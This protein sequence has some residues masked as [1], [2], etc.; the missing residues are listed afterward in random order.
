MKQGRASLFM[1]LACGL[2]APMF[3]LIKWAATLAPMMQVIY[4]HYIA[5]LLVT[6]GLFLLTR[7][8]T[9]AIEGKK[10]FALRTVFWLTTTLCIFSASALLPVVHVSLLLN[11]APLFVPIFAMIWL[12]EKI[13]LM[14][15]FA[16]SVAFMGAALVLKPVGVTLDMRGLIFGLTAAVATAGSMLST[17]KLVQKNSPLLLSLYL[18]AI[19]VITTSFVLPFTWEPMP[20]EALLLS[21]ASGSIFAVELYCFTKAFAYSS[22]ARLGPFNYAGVVISGLVSWLIWND[23]IDLLSWSGIALVCIGGSLSF[24]IPRRQKTLVGALRE[25]SRLTK[26][27]F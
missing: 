9:W 10:L 11:T 1:L 8:K 7:P 13:P 20:T 19:G 15:W 22:A 4:F 23:H 3:S 21:L 18:L 16:I 17:Q 6:G 24:L 26:V 2:T 27:N 25:N 12:R 5:A 14:L